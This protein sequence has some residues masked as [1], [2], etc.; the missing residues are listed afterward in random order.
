MP[1][2]VQQW[3]FEEHY[4]RKADTNQRRHFDSK[5]AQEILATYRVRNILSCLFAD[6]TKFAVC[7]TLKIFHVKQYEICKGYKGRK[8]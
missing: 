2:E 6:V 5:L 8:K 1:T 3:S 7:C 4:Q